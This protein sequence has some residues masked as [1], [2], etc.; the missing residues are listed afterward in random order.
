MRGNSIALAGKVYP[1]TR[2]ET[3]LELRYSASGTAFINFNLSC[4]THKDGDENQ[5]TSYQCVAFGEMAE[6]MAESLEPGDDVLAFGRIQA[7]NWT[8]DDGDRRY[9]QKVVIDEI[10][11]TLR[12]S[13]VGIN[14]AKREDRG[15]SGGSR[16]APRDDYGPDEAPF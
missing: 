3:T 7:N 9:G 1:K 5:Y 14:R 13:T 16:P 2:D 10:G 6:N 15:S 12:W 11:P 4:W 8:T